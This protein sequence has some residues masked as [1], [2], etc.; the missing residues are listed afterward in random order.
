[1]HTWKISSF[2]GPGVPRHRGQHLPPRGTAA[3]IPN[4][5]GRGNAAA[6]RGAEHAGS[7]GPRG[8]YGMG[9]MSTPDFAKPWFINVY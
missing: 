4:C 1:M 7:E 5:H 8:G 2:P 3:V 6:R 9:V